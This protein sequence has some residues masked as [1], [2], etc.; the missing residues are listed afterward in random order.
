[1]EFG[2]LVPV[3]VVVFLGIADF[4]LAYHDQLQLSSALASGAQYGFAQGQTETG[5]TL[6]SD[7]TGFINKVSPIPL[8]SVTASYNNG[9]TG[10]TCYC[11]SGSPA[12][13]TASASCGATC[14]DG[15]GNVLGTSGNY[16]SITGSFTYAP[17]FILQT[18]IFGTSYS[19]T[20][21]VRLK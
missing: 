11:V 1:M 4:S 15:S 2:L 7:V 13:Y 10:T 20:V 16:L 19:Q 8:S 3:L 6:T 18:V 5:T 9:L 17:M 14:T 21:T 12:A